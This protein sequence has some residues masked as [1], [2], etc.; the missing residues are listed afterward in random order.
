M[1][2]RDRQ[3]ATR[4]LSIAVVGGLLVMLAAPVVVAAQ[5]ASGEGDVK[6]LT[7]P[8]NYV[9][10]G[11]LN[12][13][14][15]S[16]KFGEYTGYDRSGVYALGNFDLRGGDAWCQGSGIVRWRAS[17]ANLGTTS[18]NVDLSA[19]AQGQW[20]FGVSFDQLRHYTTNGSYQTPLQGAPG[21]NVFLLG[22]G[23]GVINTT[24]TTTNGVL[25]SAN[26]GTQTLT[27]TQLAAF[28]RENIH[29]ERD[30]TGLSAGY[31]FNREW[32]VKFDFKR[33]DQSGAKLIA[34]GTDAYNLTGSGGFNYGGERILI[35][36]NPTAYSNDTFNLALSWVGAQAYA[37][38][39]YY[40][41]L[42]HDDF[43]GVSFSNPY[44]S[45]GTGNAPVP[46]PGTS[47]GAAFPL[48]TMSTPP[49][50]QFRQINATGGY[51]FSPATK[52][53]GGLS[54]GLNT[55]NAGFDGTYTTTPNTVPVLPVASFRGRVLTKHADARLSHQFNPA[56]NVNAG[57]KYN[58]RVNES[59]SNSYTF[60]DL[61]GVKETAVNI[62]MSNKREQFDAAVD[63]RIDPRQRLHVGYEYEHIE[64]WCNNALANNA[65]GKLSAT[66]AGY[67]V[68]ASCV[69]VPRNTENKLVTAYK[70]KLAEKIEFSAGYTY[71][72]RSARVNPSFY[73][74]MQTN[75]QGF[76]NYG[77]LA[78]FDASRRENLF[79]AGVNWQA[80]DKFSIGLNGRHT[81]DDYY[82]SALGVQ[83]GESSSANLDANY[84]LSENISFG[85]YASW[86]KRTRDL[87]TAAGRNAVAPLSTLWANTLADRDNTVGLNGRQKGLLG[88]KV[89]LSED[90][91]YG[92]SKS[93]YYTTLVQN[94]APAVGNL[95][96]SPNISSE[97]GQFRLVG[98]YELSPFS[99]VTVGYL[100][101]RLKSS[102]YYYSAYQFGFTPTSLLP[103]GQQA[104]NYSVNTVFATY[105]Y[106]FR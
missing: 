25:T 46:A 49:S 69:Q 100:Y 68:F 22:P 58:E 104:P 1:N 45:G 28:R 103:T 93:K 77:F 41:S 59:P 81:K 20:A 34:G 65:Q 70:L 63:W 67:Y 48:T 38:V 37:S 24:T 102:D 13:P 66:N 9:E 32:S 60:Y 89:E 36:P 50:N 87:L 83:N 90:L 80:T 91:T 62:P 92:L 17:G 84:S 11:A 88:G 12:V 3:F 4:S 18:R 86:Q 61:G 43:S 85:A 51:I 99:H 98:T 30:N 53:T 40:A 2:M 39:A 64:R 19:T 14:T 15:D 16:P 42:F 55:Q 5:D 96:T 105:R 29:N 82:D 33:L 71:A 78:F 21:G 76:E 73:N 72:D 97:L 35:L 79:K 95:G 94:I 23:F 54:Y 10:I 27:S 8:T 74:P 106:S 7:C 101:Q 56:F 26:K 52:L 31:S 44:V 47:P 6:A 75:N 57:F